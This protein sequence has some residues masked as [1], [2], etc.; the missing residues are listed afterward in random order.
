MS[1]VT[2]RA[3]GALLAVGMAAIFLALG[4]DSALAAASTK[5]IFVNAFDSTGAIGTSAGKAIVLLAF[6]A[7]ALMA[8]AG[9]YGAKKRSN[10]PNDPSA[11]PGVIAVLLVVGVLLMG[12]G[13]FSESGIQS[14]FGSDAKLGGSEGF[15]NL[16]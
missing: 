14:F 4:A 9:L 11:Q 7:G 1:K 3:F 16:K 13:W 10:N 8:I 6:P 2:T 15:T 5:N 12:F